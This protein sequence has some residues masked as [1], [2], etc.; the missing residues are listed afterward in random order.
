M[1]AEAPAT[2]G[3]RQVARYT[4]AQVDTATHFNNPVP[5]SAGRHPSRNAGQARRYMWAQV[6]PPPHRPRPAK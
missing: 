5:A 6:A 2:S 4:R 1:Q 3:D